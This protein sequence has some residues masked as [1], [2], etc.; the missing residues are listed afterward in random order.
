MCSC[1]PVGFIYLG[2]PFN[3]HRNYSAPVGIAAGASYSGAV[4]PLDTGHLMNSLSSYS[5]S[6]P[7]VIRPAPGIDPVGGIPFP[8]PARRCE[9][10]CHHPTLPVVHQ[11]MTGEA[12]AHFFPRAEKLFSDAL[13]F[14]N[15]PSTPKCSADSRPRCRACYTTASKHFR[16]TAAS[17]NRLRFFANTEW[18]EMCPMMFKLRNH[19]NSR[20]Y[21]SRSQLFR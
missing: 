20:S 15:V 3:S 11:Q 1:A 13:A 19:V 9:H 12:Q 5:R 21:C 18:S 17:G 14:I 8:A 10:H 4:Q 16:D 6:A 2:L 7:T